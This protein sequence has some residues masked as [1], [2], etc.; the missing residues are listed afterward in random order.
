[1]L[2][3]ISAIIM[4]VL[5]CMGVFISIANFTASDLDAADIRMNGR[6]ELIGPYVYCVHGG[7]ACISGTVQEIFGTIN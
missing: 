1:M 2:K 6:W 4:A 5:M 3:K 7:N